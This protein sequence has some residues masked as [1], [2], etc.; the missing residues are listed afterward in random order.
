MK[1]STMLGLWL[2]LTISVL[3]VNFGIMI[4]KYG[5]ENGQIDAINKKIYY[6]LITQEDNAT[7][8][9]Y[10]K[11]QYPVT[12]GKK[13]ENNHSRNRCNNKGKDRNI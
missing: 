8:W 13:N 11:E 4:Y 9:V 5:Y 7:K 12:K 10:S 2:S 6:Q 3:L 1:D